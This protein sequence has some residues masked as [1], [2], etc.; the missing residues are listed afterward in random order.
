MRKNLQIN[1]FSIDED[2]RRIIFD[3]E[4][5]FYDS[6]D[7]DVNGRDDDDS[8]T[9]FFGA[10]HSDYDNESNFDDYDDDLANDLVYEP[11]YSFTND[12][13]DEYGGN[14]DNN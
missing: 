4:E 2:E 10:G 11:D 8:Y 1:V 5:E 13:C 9:S 14:D 6:D 3:E 12:N 7:Y